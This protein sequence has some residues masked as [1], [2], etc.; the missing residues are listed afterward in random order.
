MSVTH[1][2][3]YTLRATCPLAAPLPRTKSKALNHAANLQARLRCKS[4]C[5][6]MPAGMSI[7]AVWVLTHNLFAATSHPHHEARPR[8]ASA[9]PLAHQGTKASHRRRRRDAPLSGTWDHESKPQD[10][11]RFLAS[12]SPDG[13]CELSKHCAARKGR[14]KASDSRQAR[15]VGTVALED[16]S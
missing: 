7:L 3:L 14:A 2:L 5:A 16:T 8:C 15:V 1:C 12:A 9:R 13:D 11:M 6:R 10:P 4:S